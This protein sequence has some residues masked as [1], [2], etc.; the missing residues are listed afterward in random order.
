MAGELSI[1]PVVQKHDITSKSVA[2]ALDGL[3]RAAEAAVV[4]RGLQILESCKTD[5]QGPAVAAAFI[6]ETKGQNPGLPAC[7]WNEL[8]VAAGSPELTVASTG[9]GGTPSKRRKQS[10]V[11]QG[12]AA[13]VSAS[14]SEGP[15]KQSS[16]V[17]AALQTQSS[18]A[19]SHSGSDAASSGPQPKSSAKKLRKM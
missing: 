5:P 12:E 7:F 18:K 11:N 1:T 14:G 9:T 6:K 15:A 13:S 3:R 2:V 10:T 8:D 16:S 17:A 4:I 19:S